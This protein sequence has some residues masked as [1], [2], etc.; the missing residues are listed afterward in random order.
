MGGME[1]PLRA[2]AVLRHD[3][4]A[5]PHFDLLFESRPGGDLTTFRLDRWP[6][7]EATAGV[8]LRDHRRLYLTYEGPVPGDRGHVARVDEGT[9]EAREA[10]GGWLLCR[11]DGAAWLRIDPAGD[12]DPASYRVRPAE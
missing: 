7:R 1:K 5:E 12:G 9:L 10:D 2:F 3:G 8:R 6:V 4:V 11:G